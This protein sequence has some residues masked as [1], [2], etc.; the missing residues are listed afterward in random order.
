MRTS[1]T[2]WSGIGRAEQLWRRD[3]SSPRHPFMALL[4]DVPVQ[5]C[6]YVTILLISSIV[7]APVRFSADRGI[8]V[9]MNWE[10]RWCLR[11][12]QVTA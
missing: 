6:M 9:S 8:G 12:W 4:E 1:V 11:S 7:T 2:V 10:S 3:S 5:R